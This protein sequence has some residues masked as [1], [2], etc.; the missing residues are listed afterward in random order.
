[1]D[2]TFACFKRDLETT[3]KANIGEA[4]FEQCLAECQDSLCIR[5]RE[6]AVKSPHVIMAVAGKAKELGREP[7]TLKNIVDRIVALKK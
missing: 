4:L 2:G 5:K 7:A 3:L 1:V 6:H